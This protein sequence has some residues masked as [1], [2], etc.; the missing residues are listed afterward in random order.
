MS[1]PL[2]EAPATLLGA[3]DMMSGEMPTRMAR[4]AERIGPIFR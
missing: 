4:E 3:M 1:K 2:G